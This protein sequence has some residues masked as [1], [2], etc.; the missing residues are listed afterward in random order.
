MSSQITRA[1]A[2]AT[3][4]NYYSTQ[5][6]SKSLLF[7]NSN[8]AKLILDLVVLVIAFMRINSRINYHDIA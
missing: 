4:L 1:I 3:R 8:R 6:A 5:H 7:V 2:I